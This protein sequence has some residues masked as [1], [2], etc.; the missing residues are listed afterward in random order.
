MRNAI[1]ST[2]LSSLALGTISAFAQ[3]PIIPAK[4]V[5]QTQFPVFENGFQSRALANFRLHLNYQSDT[6]S[7]LLLAEGFSLPLPGGAH[8]LELTYQQTGSRP[9]QLSAWIDGKALHHNK[10][11]PAGG[12]QSFTS[13]DKALRTDQDFTVAASFQSTGDGSLFSKC[14]P[15]GPWSKGSKALFIKGGRLT[16][17]VGWVGALRGPAVSDGKTHRVVLRSSKGIIDLAVDGKSIGTKKLTSPDVSTHLFKIGLGASDFT[18]PLNKGTVSN[19]RY[20]ARALEGPELTSLLKGEV[21]AVNTPDLN[22]SASEYGETFEPTEAY[23]ASLPK[24]LDLPKA[25]KSPTVVKQGKPFELMDFGPVLNWTFQ[26][27]RGAGGK[28]KNIAQKGINVRLDQGEGGV[29]KGSAWMVYDE[30]TMRVATAYSGDFVDWR[31]I[32]FDGSHGSH[33]SI[34]GKPLFINPDAPAWEHPIKHSWDD[35]RIVGRDDR[36]YGRNTRQ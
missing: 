1:L 12:G 2:V 32:A 36:H 19:L 11:L 34:A 3:V 16:Y 10:S 17:D 31:G 4:T 33:T 14:A 9:S 20:W 24:A 22:W 7:E 15:E 23:L 5:A 8:L 6:A 30:D 25:P 26:I 18:G 13:E 21:E 28:N 35:E 27:N 29:S